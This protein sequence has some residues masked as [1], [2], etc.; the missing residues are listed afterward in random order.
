MSTP[1]S[2]DL[3]PGVVSS[4]VQTPRGRFA[5]HHAQVE[6]PRAHVLLVPG[7][8]GSKEDFTPL[9]PLVAGAGFSVTAYDQRGQHETSASDADDFS[10]GALAADAAA[11]AETLGTTPVHLL[12]HSFGGLV[13][14]TAAIEHTARWASLS[15]LCTGPAALGASPERPLDELVARLD[16]PEP[17]G[18]VYRALKASSLGTHPPEIEA[19]LLRRF[20]TNSRVGLRALTQHLLDAPDRVA[21]VAAT[22]LPAW[23]GRGAGDDAWPHA[24]QDDLAAR[25]GTTVQVVPGADHSPAVENPVS[26]AAAWLPF[27]EDLT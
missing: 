9:L 21:E 25:L 12:G 4:T 20:E 26:L 10:L 22:G 18:D 16:G 19:F 8:T 1:R 3:P 7:W 27:L 5:V 2:L 14:Q 24:V 6:H 23:V 13:A 17:I 15:L 11:L